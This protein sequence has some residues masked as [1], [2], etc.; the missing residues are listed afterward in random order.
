MMVSNTGAVDGDE[1]VQVYVQDPVAGDSNIVR[2]WKRLAGFARVSIAAGETADVAI[3][4]LHDDLAFHDD[5]MVWGLKAGEYVISV[6]GSS[7]GTGEVS[8]SVVV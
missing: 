1:V 3:D 4:I 2:F 6:A 7:D 8:A 5:A